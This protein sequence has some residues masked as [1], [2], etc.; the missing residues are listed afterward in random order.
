MCIFA[1]RKDVRGGD[2]GAKITQLAR[3]TRRLPIGSISER[4]NLIQPVVVVVEVEIVVV[5][6][7][8]FVSSG[9]DC[10]SLMTG[11][12][13]HHLNHR[14]HHHRSVCYDRYT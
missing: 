13:S 2:F 5:V 3:K 6:V 14:L 7:C 10:S 4:A 11:E 8:L 12:Q 9:S 1:E